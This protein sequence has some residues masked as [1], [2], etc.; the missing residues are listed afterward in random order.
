M[1]YEPS[2]K[3][4]EV[5]SSNL[6]EELGQ[7]SHVFSDK[8]GTLTCNMMEFRKLSFGG[9]IYGTDERMMILD[10]PYN[11]DFVDPSFDS[12]IATDFLLCLAVCHTIVTDN[13]DNLEYRASSPD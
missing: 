10:K 1:Y 8:T 6:N 9:Q 5:H 3:P 7:I 13:R 11:V 2:D 4:A 12:R